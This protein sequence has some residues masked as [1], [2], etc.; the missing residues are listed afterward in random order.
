MDCGMATPLTDVY[1][2]PETSF[3]AEN[4][5]PGLT[6]HCRVCAFSIAGRGKWSPIGQFQT[7]PTTPHPPRDLRVRGR[8]GQMSISLEWGEKELSNE[9]PQ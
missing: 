1:T 7:P 6:Y 5:T 3:L 9:H 2:G 8:P 4:L